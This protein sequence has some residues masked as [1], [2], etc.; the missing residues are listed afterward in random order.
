MA[1]TSTL[2]YQDN[3]D[4][5][6]LSSSLS[7]LSR[8]RST[9][10]L[11]VRTY[12][13]ATSLY[14]TKRFKEALEVLEPIITVQ[15][16]END[17]HTNGNGNTAAPIAQSSKTTRTKVWVFYLSLLH[18]I[19]DLGAEEGKLIFGSSHWKALA[20]KAREGTVWQ[21]II[22]SGYGGEEASV[23]AD[24]VVNLATLLLGHMNTQKLNQQR[25]E[26]WLATNDGESQEEGGTS[27]PK[28][29][30]SRLKVLELYTL[31]VL[32]ANEEWEY[33]KQF[34]E[35]SDSLDEERREAFLHALE[36]LKDEKDGT[37]VRERELA[38]QRE[39][40]MDEQRRREEE[41]ARR[42]EE[43]A[44][45]RKAEEEKQAKSKGDTSSHASVIGST[46]GVKPTP[47]PTPTSRPGPR[48]PAKKP[49]SR[50]PPAPPATLYRRASYVLQSLQST[51]LQASR[52]MGLGGGGSSFALF[53]FLMFMLAFVLVAAR[54]DVRVRVRRMVE[55]GWGKVRRTVGM[56]VKVSYM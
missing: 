36:D 53:R 39:R 7:S 5:A 51:I 10:S 44:G 46:G 15:T 17:K 3:A 49:L 13:E 11:I 55:E 6:Y 30:A 43:E 50:P 8:S 12:K 2:T 47:K 25:L 4:T 48:T 9:N 21:D 34:I 32:P 37:A 33:A 18:A 29:L 1:P 45:R 31:H 52:G 40:E 28:T 42:A 27:T 56:G 14:L 23:D 35:M 26:T 24:V 41:E 54:R 22:Q 19:I 38:A 16:P 20:S